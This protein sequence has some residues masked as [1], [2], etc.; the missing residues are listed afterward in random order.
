MA[1][2]DRGSNVLYMCADPYTY[3]QGYMAMEP[4]GT[5]QVRQAMA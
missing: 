1:T 5:T 4:G 2:Q 3:Y